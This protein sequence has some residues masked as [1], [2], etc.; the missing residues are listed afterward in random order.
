M[1][2]SSIQEFQQSLSNINLYRMLATFSDSSLF[3]SML[4]ESTD[5]SVHHTLTVYVSVLDP[6]VDFIGIRWL[7]V[8]NA[9]AITSELL[10]MIKDKGS[11]L[12]MLPVGIYV[13]FKC[14]D[15]VLP[16]VGNC[17]AHGIQHASWG[18]SW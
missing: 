8:A 2:Y 7:S 18:G 9:E 10:G 6:S 16:G 12:G 15:R 1:N 14:K 13:M 4:D 3:N 5:M 11:D 17:I